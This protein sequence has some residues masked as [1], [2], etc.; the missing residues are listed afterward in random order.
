MCNSGYQEWNFFYLASLLVLFFGYFKN[1]LP[2]RQ[3]EVTLSYPEKV[4]VLVLLGHIN[5]KH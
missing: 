2:G 4:S 3:K 5:R 1:P